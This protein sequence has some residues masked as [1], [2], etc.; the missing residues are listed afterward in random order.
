MLFLNIIEKK[1]KTEIK[2]TITTTV[3]KQPKDI[4]QCQRVIPL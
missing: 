2:T 1:R 3:I 4:I